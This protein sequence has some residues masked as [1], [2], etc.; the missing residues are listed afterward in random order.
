[1]MEDFQTEWIQDIGDILLADYRG[2]SCDISEPNTATEQVIEVQ[3]SPSQKALNDMIERN[4]SIGLLVEKL[5][6]EVA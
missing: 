1:M 6:L 2:N 5:S 4:P 3:V